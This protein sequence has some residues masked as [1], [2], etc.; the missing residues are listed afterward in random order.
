MLRI[1][2][3]LLLSSALQ[4]LVIEPEV[5]LNTEKLTPEQSEDLYNLKDRIEAYLRG[6]DWYEEAEHL[7]IGLPIAINFTKAVESGTGWEYTAMFYSGNRGDIIIDEPVWRFQLP[8]GSFEYNE[9]RHDSFLA[10]INFHVFLILGYELDKLGEFAGNE[11]FQ[12]ARRIGMQARLDERSDGWDDRMLRLEELLDPRYTMYRS[13]RWVTH[14][15]YWFRS[16][17]N[18]DYEAWKA[19]RLALDMVEEID[20]ATMLRGYFKANHRSLCEIL[21]KGRDEDG[22]FLIMRLDNTDRERSEY[23]QEQLLRING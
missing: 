13:L 4:A 1:L 23:Y 2:F 21:I 7:T 20:N 12:N 22:L 10:M 9:N 3:L 11:A 5:S 15:A 16:V 8:S 18:N 19:A 17:M 14:T 6:R